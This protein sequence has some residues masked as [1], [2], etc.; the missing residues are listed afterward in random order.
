MDDVQDGSPRHAFR[1]SK[2]ARELV[3][4]NANAAGKALS[5]L[6]TSLVEES[7]NPRWACRRFIRSMGVRNKK[8]YRTWTAQE[9]QRLLKLIDLHP[10]NEISRLMRRSHS[11]IWHM[12]Q[13]LGANAKMGK[14]SFTKYTLAIALH[15][16]PETVDG[17]IRRGWLRARE[18]ETGHGRRTVIEAEDF[19]AFCKEHTKDVVGNRLSKE[20]LDF[21]YQPWNRGILTESQVSTGVFV[22][23]KIRLQDPAQA[24]FV[25]DHHTV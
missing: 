10:V 21:V 19:C 3:R 20:R 9:Q 14:D 2:A 11:S 23:F 12:L 22:I 18:I 7:G 8:P 4:A 6:L 13:R 17:W 24:L 25:E 1:W 5:V 16:R 15:V